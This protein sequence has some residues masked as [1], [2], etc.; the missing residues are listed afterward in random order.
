MGPI[1]QR[2]RILTPNLRATAWLGCGV[3]A[4]LGF[5]VDFFPHVTVTI[6]LLPL[7]GLAAL[8]M[9]RVTELSLLS[10]L[11][12]VL[13]LLPFSTLAGYLYDRDFA[14]VIA[15]NC[16]PLCQ[17]HQLIN[18]MLVMAAVGFCGLIA[19]MEW[20]SGLQTT[21]SSQSK[22]SAIGFHQSTLSVGLSGLLLVTAVVLSW[23]HAP[24]L[25]I[26]NKPYSGGISPDLRASYLISYLLLILVYID[27][28]REV[29]CSRRQRIKGTLLTLATSYIVIVLQF[30]RGDRECAGLLAGMALLYVTG[31]N[32]SARAASP[33]PHSSQTRR[34]MRL[35]VPAITCILILMFLG[36]VRHLWSGVLPGAAGTARLRDYLTENTWTAVAR[37]NLG[38]ATDYH[39]GTLD[40]LWGQTYWDY[41]GSLPPSSITRKLG[42]TR[43]MDGPSNPATWYICLVSNGGMH[44]VV[45]PFRN[46][47]IWG[48]LPVLFAIGAA[49]AAIER[50]NQAG[51][52][53]ARL[54]YGSVSTSSM[55]WFWYG[56]MNMVRTV[57]VWAILCGLYAFVTRQSAPSS[58]DLR[59]IPRPR[60]L[61][62]RRQVSDA[63][64]K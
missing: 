27:A 24:K 51:T 31:H 9:L 34:A 48:V 63:A 44:P 45:V 8:F 22:V 29:S 61:R 25:T 39:Y 62:S 55:L 20:C 30:L 52:I 38:V 18:Q 46:F 10:R 13:Y 54:L 33:V 43:P 17:N 40:Y 4:A 12:V 35:A 5:T 53:A 21:D 60:F 11:F 49:I 36:S 2:V 28:E 19:G 50:F 7:M 47:G 41:L 57:M 26:F 1:T 42:Y 23:L 15:P 32:F 56:D 6:A 58:T 16:V 59:V 14:W 37:N 64:G 3:I